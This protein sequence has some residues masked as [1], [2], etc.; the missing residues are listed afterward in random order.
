M[1]QLKTLRDLLL[2]ELRDLYSAENQLLVALPKMTNTAHDEDLQASF[3]EHFE[4]TKMHVERLEQIFEELGETPEGSFCKGMQGLIEEGNKMIAEDA[5]A[6]VHD[7]GLIAAA[8][9]IEH[10]EIAAYGTTRAFAS[11]LGEDDAVDLL[12]ETLEE[13]KA[14][15][16]KLTALAESAIN[17]EAAEPKPE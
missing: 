4:Q 9:R 5:E 11:I 3:E 6:A 7:A 12:A 13:E 8:Q 2:H 1:S 17:L 15:D 16:E 10:Y 14:T